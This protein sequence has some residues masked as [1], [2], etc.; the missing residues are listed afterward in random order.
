MAFH[1]CEAVTQTLSFKNGASYWKDSS[2]MAINSSGRVA[3]L[4][5][6]S[7]PFLLQSCCWASD[8]QAVKRGVSYYLIPFQPLDWDQR[9]V[10]VLCCWCSLPSLLP[11]FPWSPFTSPQRVRM[12]W[13]DRAQKRELSIMAMARSQEPPP[14]LHPHATCISQWETRQARS[15]PSTPPAPDPFPTLIACLKSTGPSSPLHVK[16]NT[17]CNVCLPHCITLLCNNVNACEQS[18]CY[19]QSTLQNETKHIPSHPRTAF[20]KTKKQKKDFPNHPELLLICWTTAPACGQH[21]VWFKCVFLEGSLNIT[22]YFVFPS[23]SVKFTQHPRHDH[24]HRDFILQSEVI[25]KH[26]CVHIR[27]S[28][29]HRSTHNTFGMNWFNLLILHVSLFI[30]QRKYQHKAHKNRSSLHSL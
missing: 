2:Y 15:Y 23:G 13:E 25:W 19:T 27:A 20:K 29:V 6:P 5:P 24:K 8:S 18:E 26:L 10:F 4:F 9:R 1:T 11:S 28:E 14:Q 3:H 17:Y 16:S 30:L 22:S 21:H 12:R 7:V